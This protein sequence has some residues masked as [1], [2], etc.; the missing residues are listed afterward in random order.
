MVVPTNRTTVLGSKV[1]NIQRNTGLFVISIDVEMAW[2]RVHH[3]DGAAPDSRFADER[4]SVAA[5]LDLMEQHEIAAT[6]A[7]VGHLFLD[8]CSPVNGLHHPEVLR[9]PYPWFSGDWFADDPAT[10]ARGESSWYAPDLIEAIKACPVNQEIGSHSFSHQI[11]GDPA[12]DADTFRSELTA[13]R[14]AAAKS[15]V[16]LRSFV[17]PRNSIGD[18]QVLTEHGFVAYR[19]PTPPRFPERSWLVRPFLNLGDSI[20]PV[21]ATAVYPS[22]EG[23]LCNVPQT[24]FFDPDSRIAR[25]LGRH[26]WPKVIIRRLDQAA[27]HGSLFHLW[28]HSHDVARAPDRALEGLDQLFRAAAREREAGTLLNMTMG[29]VARRFNNAPVKP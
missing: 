24:Y 25:L 29:Q 27:R 4:R 15:G 9:A 19:G 3:G 1:L 8:G 17:Y 5:L 16:Q 12:C 23:K 21:E 26:L 2:G 11:I 28:F 22:M 6:W 10:S 18:Q 20:I 13:C 7:V 14:E